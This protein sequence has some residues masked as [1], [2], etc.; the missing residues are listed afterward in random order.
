M[1]IVEHPS[2]QHRGKI[3]LTA[4]RLQC[5]VVR[6]SD[7]YLK[8]RGTKSNPSFVPGEFQS[9]RME[10]F[11]CFSHANYGKDYSVFK[12]WFILASEFHLK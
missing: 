4:I 7:S 2:V 1:C 3:F 9:S 5:G 11:A 6:I 8:S 12:I 10:P